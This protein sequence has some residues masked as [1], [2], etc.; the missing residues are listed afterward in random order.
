MILLTLVQ[1][2]ISNVKRFSWLVLYCLIDQH[3]SIA[4][5]LTISKVQLKYRKGW[6]GSRCAVLP[7]GAGSATVLE[8]TYL[9]HPLSVEKEGKERHGP[10]LWSVCK[11]RYAVTAE[12]SCM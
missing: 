12:D 11:D 8:F 4:V 7:P 10:L 1:L 3:I 2:H 9:T 5:S 6:S